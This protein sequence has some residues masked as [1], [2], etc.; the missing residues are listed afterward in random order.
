MHIVSH[1][2]PRE[3]SAGQKKVKHYML[4]CRDTSTETIH[5]CKFV[6]LYNKMRVIH[7]PAGVSLCVE[8]IF[9]ISCLFFTNMY[10]HS[11]RCY[12]P[13]L[14]LSP[15]FPRHS[16]SPAL[17]IIFAH[18][19]LFFFPQFPQACFLITD[20]CSGVARVLL[21]VAYHSVFLAHAELMTLLCISV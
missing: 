2:H 14:D 21:T 16:L 3:S 20:W 15:R 11:M 4:K 1:A 19:L 8:Y 12:I 6:R 9:S 17:W 10:E 5:R 7:P 13:E 18:F